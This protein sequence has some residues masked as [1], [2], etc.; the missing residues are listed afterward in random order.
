M[1]QLNIIRSLEFVAKWTHPCQ[2]LC[3]L[4]KL[5]FRITNHNKRSTYIRG[6]HCLRYH[7]RPLVARLSPDANCIV[8][9]KRP[10][11]TLHLVPPEL[12]PDSRRRQFS[13]YA[14]AVRT[15]ISK[16]W[17]PPLSQALW[18]TPEWFRGQPRFA[19]DSSDIPPPYGPNPVT[20]V[21]NIF[22]ACLQEPQGDINTFGGIHSSVDAG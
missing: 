7:L 3:V 1:Y 13:P 6:L 16:S 14:T 18:N 4:H 17:W 10:H 5:R 9:H 20:S 22:P 11:A 12:T 8:P 2:A 15:T 21:L 19:D